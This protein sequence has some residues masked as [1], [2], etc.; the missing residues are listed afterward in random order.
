MFSEK[1]ALLLDMNS[2]FMFGEDRFSESEDYSI[3]YKKTGG[4]LPKNLVNEIINNVLQYLGERYPDKKY[5]EKFP[6]VEEAIKKVATNNLS[7]KEITNLI[8]TFSYHEHG[9]IP[10]EYAKALFKLQKNYKLAVVID[11]WA[12][13]ERW[14]KTF[15][16]H[17]IN[18]LFSASSFSSDH[19]MVKPSPKPFQLVVE[20]L[21]IPKKQC[22]VIGDSVRR[23]LGGA[24]LAGIDC[25]LVGGASDSTALAS[26][27]TLLEFCSKI[28]T[29]K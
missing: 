14:L 12:P 25:I 24:K 1:R 17:R 6:T 26:Y 2:T 8:N 13:K 4:K 23:D 5:R 18:N 28:A 10:V 11:I 27:S 9:H 21:G 22:L 7:S 19:G 3:F 15:E 29:N 16:K 20:E